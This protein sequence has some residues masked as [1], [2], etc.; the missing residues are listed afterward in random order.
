[1]N[2]KQRETNNKQRE[3]NNKQRETSNKQRETND[4]QRET[5]N[6]QRE[7]NN[8]QRETNNK[9]RET[10][11]KQ[12]ETNNKQWETRDEWIWEEWQ[13]ILQRVTSNEWKYS[14]ATIFLTITSSLLRQI[15]WKQIYF[16]LLCIKIKVIFL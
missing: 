5:N 9:Q 2:N 1:M 7:T 10:N 8:K 3:T 14:F 11:N 6:K 16:F 15:P 12:R 4:K 13:A